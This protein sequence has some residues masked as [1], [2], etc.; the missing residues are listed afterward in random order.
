MYHYQDS[1]IAELSFPYPFSAI[2]VFMIQIFYN[3]LQGLLL[4]A[5]VWFALHVGKT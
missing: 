1:D 2:T 5:Y 3:G 4:K